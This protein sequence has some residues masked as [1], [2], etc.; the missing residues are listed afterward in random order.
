M[1]RILLFVIL[2]PFGSSANSQSID[3]NVVTAACTHFD[4]FCGIKL[5]WTLG[6]AMTSKV[7]GGGQRTVDLP[8]YLQQEQWQCCNTI[9]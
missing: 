6:E 4:N 2:L 3:N 1:K 8:V 9:N 7:T 5:T